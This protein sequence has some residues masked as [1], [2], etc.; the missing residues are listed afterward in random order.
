MPL[1]KFPYIL[2]DEDGDAYGIDSE[3]QAKLQ[4][5][6]ECVTIYDCSR[7]TLL[8]SIMELP[9]VDDIEVEEDEDDDDSEE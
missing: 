6:N 5:K 8:G 4:A 1:R 7:G 9:E 3:E 2:V